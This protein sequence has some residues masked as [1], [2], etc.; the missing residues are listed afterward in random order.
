MKIAKFHL[1]LVSHQASKVC[2]EF[3]GGS[4]SLMIS[5]DFAIN[6]SMPFV[7]GDLDK[8]KTFVHIFDDT[9]LDLVMKN[10]DTVADFVSYL[11]KKER[12]L[13]SGINVISAGE[14]ELLAYYLKNINEQDEHD[15]VIPDKRATALA[16]GESIWEGFINNPQC[17]AQKKAD[18][19]SYFWDSLIEL[20]SGHALAGTQY[21][22]Q[23][24]NFKISEKILRFLA[25]ASRF[26]RRILS[27]SFIEILEKTPKNI[28][29]LRCV[30]PV[31]KT[32]P[33]YVFLLFPW[34]KNKSEKINRKVR[35]AYLEACCKVVKLRYPDAEDIVGIATE[36]GRGASGSE[37]VAYLDG[38]I[39]TKEMEEDTKKIQKE[40]GILINPTK[41]YVHDKEYPESANRSLA[42]KI[43]KNPR[44]KP[45]PCG[46][47]KKYKRCHGK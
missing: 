16:F 11:S 3:H 43:P 25:K 7:V 35:F 20:F 42:L 14:E 29:M 17:I 36:S 15:F 44:N 28:R 31:K 13:R 39:W 19:V 2:K 38:R 24:D 21:F 41:K 40:L 33:F 10:V 27:N 47:G 34:R 6:S 37:D 23:K 12:F 30:P 5:N 45:C 32:N 4:G 8:K 9:T 46:S 22:K 18:K 26:E 1:V